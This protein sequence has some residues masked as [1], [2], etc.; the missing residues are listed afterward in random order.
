MRILLDTH[1][2]LWCI[3]NDRRLSK[4]ARNKIASAS[5]VYISSASIWEATIKIKLKKLDA[6]IEQLVEA[7]AESGFLE[8]PITAQHAAGISQLPD[9]HR[10]P[11]DRMLIAQAIIEPLTLLTANAELKNYSELVEVI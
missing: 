8:L 11:F 2:F 10:D 3:K 6:D 4:A 9:I 5:D 1:V 7:I